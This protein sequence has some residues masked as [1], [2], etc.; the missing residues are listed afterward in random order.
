ML[1]QTP[2]P[3]PLTFCSIALYPIHSTFLPQ[4]GPNFKAAEK[5]TPVKAITGKV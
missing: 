2:P 4:N 5:K 3:F 1:E